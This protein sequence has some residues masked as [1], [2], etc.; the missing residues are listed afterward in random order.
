MVIVHELAEIFNSSKGMR[1]PDK[2][3][4]KNSGPEVR[5]FNFRKKPAPAES[6]VLP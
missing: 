5:A 2:G 3:K 6:K 4:V 1:L